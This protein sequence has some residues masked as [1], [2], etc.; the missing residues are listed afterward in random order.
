MLMIK[1]EKKVT[2]LISKILRNDKDVILKRNDHIDDNTIE[3]INK[4]L[5]KIRKNLRKR[6]RKIMAK[7]HN[8]NVQKQLK[9]QERTL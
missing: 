4:K 2:K 5:I 8:K 9:K 1:K 3:L 7:E 6:C